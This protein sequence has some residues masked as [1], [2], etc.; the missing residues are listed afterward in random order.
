MRRG[1]PIVRTGAQWTALACIS[2]GS[3][4]PARSTEPS[5]DL[6]RAAA[7][8]PTLEALHA[9]I[10]LPSCG[11][12]NGVCHNANEYPD[13]GTPESLQATVNARCNTATSDP[14]Q[15]H[16]LCEPAGDMLLVENGPDRGFRT[17]IGYVI[18]Q[19][20]QTP[21]VVVLTLHDAPAHDAAHVQ[22]SIV[23]DADPQNLLTIPLGPVLTTQAGQR[24]AAVAAD[25][26][27]PGLDYFLT[28]SYTPGFSAQIL[29]GDPN[30]NGIFG[31][32]LGGALVKP[33]APAKSFFVQR[34]LGVVQPQM[35][36]ANGD[37]TPEQID[38][39]ECWID[40]L[41][42]DGSNAAGPIDYATCP[43]RFPQPVSP[44]PGP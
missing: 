17:R 21:S 25:D 15:I 26:V 44:P 18:D 12:V 41:L 11:A 4:E 14:S 16:D 19:T 33:G 34:I 29:L 36:L 39:I 22:A 23:R 35:P 27:R 24:R 8:Y 1:A 30:G 37:L 7:A 3:G 20:S 42:P 10:V 32:D 38:A 43:P 28:S 6:V 40:R 2:C 13:L 9:K 5:A 31:A